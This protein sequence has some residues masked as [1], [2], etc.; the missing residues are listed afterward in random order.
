MPPGFHAIA[1]TRQHA[2][3]RDRRTQKRKIYGVQFH[4]E[5]VHTPRRADPRDLPLRR[6]R[7]QAVAGPWLVHRRCR[8]ARYARPWADSSAICGLSGGV[9]SSVAAVL[10]HKALGDRLT[11]IFVDNGLLAPGRGE[12]RCSSVPRHCQLELESRRRARAFLEA[13]DGVTDPEQKR[14][15]IGKIFI[16]VFDGRRKMSGGRLPGPGH[17]LPGR[18]RERLVQGPERGDQDHHNVGGLPE[19]M[20]LKLIEPL[21]EL[22][23]DEVRASARLG[24]PDDIV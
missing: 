21:R 12:R 14:K 6:L 19:Q 15:I 16:D 9:D 2:V 8:R 7:V 22:F 17:A 5:V 1:H 18:D 3:R 24:M 20:K 11:C 10:V 23:K 4:P 13:L